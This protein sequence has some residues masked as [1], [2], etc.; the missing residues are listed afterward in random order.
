MSHPPG[1]YPEQAG[2]RTLRWWDGR[3]WT[4]HTQ[5]AS[6]G[7]DALEFELGGDRSPD[8]I[9]RQVQDGAGVAPAAG[10]GGSLFTEPVL[11]VNQK[12]KLIELTNEYAVCDQHGNR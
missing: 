9:R 11:V 3:Q 4:P 8:E 5:Q 1:W 7:V 12:A 6:A 10:G 2:S